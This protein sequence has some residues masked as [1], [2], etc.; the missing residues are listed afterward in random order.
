[1]SLWK[2]CLVIAIYCIFQVNMP[3]DR[4]IV[5]QTSPDPLNDVRKVLRPAIE[6][7]KRTWFH[8][9]PLRLLDTFYQSRWRYSIRNVVRLLVASQDLEDRLA[10]WILSQEHGAK[11]AWT[12][13]DIEKI[14]TEPED[15]VRI[16][17]IR[18]VS[19][20]DPV[21]VTRIIEQMLLD[22]EA[23]IRCKQQCILLLD[24]VPKESDRVRLWL[25]ASG[26]NALRAECLFSFSSVISSAAVVE[27]VA[28]FLDDTSTV[29]V[30]ASEDFGWPTE[31]RTMACQALSTVAE[32]KTLAIN[33]IQKRSSIPPCQEDIDF[34]LAAMIAFHAL[35]PDSRVP[36]NRI[37]QW[38]DKLADARAIILQYL[39]GQFSH[40]VNI[41][42]QVID[43]IQEMTPN[44]KYCV[45]QWLS[46]RRSLK[47][48]QALR[49]L[50]RDSHPGIRVAAAVGLTKTDPLFDLSSM[51]DELLASAVS[52][53]EEFTIAFHSMSDAVTAL[54][55]AGQS[56]K[57]AMNWLKENRDPELKTLCDDAIDTLPTYTAGNIPWKTATTLRD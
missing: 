32:H 45:C 47:A 17:A 5:A 29:N 6:H 55:L 28:T 22:R 40:S 43:S 14:I 20:T 21:W 7:N 2:K 16:A 48:K 42:S 56:D 34:I 11:M 31:I 54:A 35:Q 41:E 49:Q 57:D 8:N 30:A 9:R 39:E 27:V 53:P 1:M 25:V 52:S 19:K 44:Q 37:M 33:E 38:Y 24:K 26:D 13:S 23:S 50:L 15:D 51:R 10:G 3:G 36:E 12:E 18:S 46:S 4:D